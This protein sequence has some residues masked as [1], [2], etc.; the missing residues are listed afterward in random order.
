MMQG[1]VTVKPFFLTEAGMVCLWQREDAK[2]TLKY[3][4]PR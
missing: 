1:D 3:E 2:G 4:G